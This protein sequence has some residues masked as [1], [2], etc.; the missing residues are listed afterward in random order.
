MIHPSVSLAFIN[1][2]V[3]HGLRATEALPAGTLIWCLDALDIRL[4]REQLVALGPL[5]DE[6][7]DRY[8]WTDSVGDRIL[9]WDIGRYMNHSCQPNS[10]SPGLQFEVALRDIAQGEEV[11]CDYGTL[12]LDA[13]FACECGTSSCRGRVTPRD[14]DTF[15][16]VWDAQLQAVFPRV[17]QVPQ[18]LAGLLDAEDL[19]AIAGYAAQPTTLPGVKAHQCHAPQPTPFLETPR[20]LPVLLR[21]LAH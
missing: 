13:G 12:N 18:A 8:A 15:A 6:Q 10:M 19:A 17:M 4:T 3:G 5:F 11:L 21:P 20:A 14:F 7:I 9:C 16:G 1:D 2:T